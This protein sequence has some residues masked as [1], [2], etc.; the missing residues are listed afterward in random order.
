[1]LTKEQR[2]EELRQFIPH[3][4]GE[5]WDLIVAGQR[6]QIIKDTQ[7]GGR[8]TLQFGTEVIS[9]ADGSVAALL[10]ASPGASTAVAIMLEVI[11]RCF[12]KR[13]DGWRE[14][15]GEMVP[16]Y[17]IKLAEH[18]DLVREL[19]EETAKTLG[20][21]RSAHPAARTLASTATN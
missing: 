12:P 7:A 14:K 11:R 21:D 3:A 10:G 2:V 8:G 1:M 15:I 17:G 20:L 5:D 9:A 19:H 6:V 18:P 13:L 4:R 16:S